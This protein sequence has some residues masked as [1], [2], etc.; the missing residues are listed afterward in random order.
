MRRPESGGISRPG[1]G[2][3]RARSTRDSLVE[4]LGLTGRLGP[5]PAAPAL[6]AAPAAGVVRA[7]HVQVGDRV[8]RG[9]GV[10]ELEV[11][12][13]AADA[14]QKTAA[15]EQ[16]ERE[17]ARQ[18]QLLADGITSARQAEEAAADA[19]QAAAAA[20]AAREL[21]AR[22]RVR[23]PIA[24]GCRTCWCS[25]GSGS[26]PAGRWRRSCRPTR[27]TWRRRCR[28]PSLRRLR[29]GLPADVAAGGRHRRVRGPA[30]R[31]RAGRGFA[32]QRGRGGD[33]RAQSRRPAASRRGRHGARA[34]LGVRTGVLVVPGLGASCS[35]GDS[36]V[37]FVVG[38]DSVAHQR[39]RDARR[40]R[41]EGGPRSRETSRDG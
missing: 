20:A 25:E 37:V 22:T 3:L 10:A 18:Q 27:S 1:A 4:T 7:V 5:S 32:H 33:P 21:L 15:A 30:R 19:R 31:A 16:A 26:T 41:R 24:G 8:A 29:T 2:R 6:L 23:S 28:R 17:A 36:S 35:P 12:E 9:A 40:S 38:P 14:R 39:V 34:R 11:P 13:L